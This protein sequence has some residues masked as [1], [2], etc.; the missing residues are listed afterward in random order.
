[1][2]ST[3]GRGCHSLRDERYRYTRYRNGEEEL[4][5]HSADPHELRN[6][7]HDPVHALAKLR[8]RSLLPSQQAAEVE[9]ASAAEKN[10]DI[11]RWDDVILDTGKP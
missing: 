3:F 6:L 8:L 11:N 4:Y 1:V 9:F 5:D 7:A 2:L 10:S